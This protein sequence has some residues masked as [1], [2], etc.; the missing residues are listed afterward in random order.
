[1]N[2]IARVLLAGSYLTVVIYVGWPLVEDAAG[3]LINA[4][5]VALFVSFTI[6]SFIRVSRPFLLSVALLNALVA[7]GTSGGLLLQAFT[8]GFTSLEANDLP[9]LVFFLVFVP[10]VGA[11]AFLQE[12]RRSRAANS[13][14]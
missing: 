3:S 11:Y 9:G 1:M 5:P 14:T 7:I 13:A 4:L 6:A 8:S 2:G 12:S 10:A